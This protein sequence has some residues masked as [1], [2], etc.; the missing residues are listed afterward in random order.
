MADK[1]KVQKISKLDRNGLNG[2]HHLIN[3][4]EIIVNCAK[5]KKEKEPKRDIVRWLI[6]VWVC[7]TFFEI[8]ENVGSI[9]C[10][11]LVLALYLILLESSFSSLTSLH[12]L[13]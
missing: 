1:Q 10:V 8:R 2:S 7:G 6:V 13:D 9:C 12:P 3:Y 4:Y 11:N 5:E